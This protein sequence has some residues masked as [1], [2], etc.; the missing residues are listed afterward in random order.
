MA[1]IFPVSSFSEVHGVPS[2]HS[3]AGGVLTLEQPDAD[4]TVFPNLAPGCFTLP[5][6]YTNEDHLPSSSDSQGLGME[7]QGEKPPVEP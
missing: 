6:K 4:G 7:V 1:L 3:P 5:E 2:S